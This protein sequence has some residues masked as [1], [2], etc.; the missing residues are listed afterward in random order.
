MPFSKKKK[1]VKMDRKR[2]ESVNGGNA[3]FAELALSMAEDFGKGIF[4]GSPVMASWEEGSSLIKE[5]IEMSLRLKEGNKA[6]VLSPAKVAGAHG[7][8]FLVKNGEASCALSAYEDQVS[9]RK[10]LDMARALCVALF[11]VEPIEEE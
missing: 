3:M 1:E 2:I 11:G 9:S 5:D 10:A 8:I 7:V 6:L 4:R